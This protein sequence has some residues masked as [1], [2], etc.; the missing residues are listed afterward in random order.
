[1]DLSKWNVPTDPRV[2]EEQELKRLRVITDM[3]AT[4]MPELESLLLEKNSDCLA[5]IIGKQEF[6]DY[7]RKYNNL[8]KAFQFG[9]YTPDCEGKLKKTVPA[10][11]VKLK[12]I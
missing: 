4:L 10:T 2:Q 11:E 5:S 6:A 12:K 3:A 9:G 1:M 7:E 8:K